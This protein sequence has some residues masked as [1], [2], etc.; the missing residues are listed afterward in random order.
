MVLFKKIIAASPLVT[1]VIAQSGG[2]PK[3]WAA[4]AFINH[5]ERVPMAA[6]LRT[7]L[8]PEGAQQL[9][10]QGTAFRA[11]YIQDG[12][13]DTDYEDI[14]TAYLQ[15]LKA[16][17]IDNDDLDIISQTEEW[18]S[19]GAMA[20]MQGFYPP[21][22]NSFDNSTGGEEIAMNLATSDN[23]T[24]YP[25]NGYQYPNIRTPTYFDPESTEVQGNA[26]CSAWLTETGTNLTENDVLNDLYESTLPF[27]QNLFSTPPLAGTIDID[28]ANIRNAYPLWE[29]V[30]YQYR[31]N[32]TVHEELKNASTT[33]SFLNTYATTMERSSNNYIDSQGDDDPLDVLYSIA[34]RTLAYKVTSQFRSNIRWG[35]SYN[36]L[37]LMFGS[38]EPIVSFIS[39]SGLLT[40]D[41]IIKEPFNALPKP[42]A[43]LV[44]ELFGEDPDFP[45]RQ[46][47]TD[48]LRVRMSYRASADAD[49]PFANQPLFKSG[50]DGIAYSRF[51]QTMNQIGRSPNQ[52]CDVC[53]PTPAPW[54]MLTDSDDHYWGDDSSS[55][56]PVISG[57]IGAIIAIAVLGLVLLALCVLGG[58]RF[59]RKS[60]AETAHDTGAVGGAAGGFKGPEKK[61]GDA[62]VV[63]TKQG[64]HHERVGSWELR[65]PNDLPPQT[66]GIVTKDLGSPHRRSLDDSD[67]DISVMNAAPVKARESV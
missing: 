47:A 32:E 4:V 14:Q 59:R 16:D 12:V 27:Y 62:D 41:N 55:L 18:V 57:V 50:P 22:P 2:G 11:R 21:S 35:S 17:V 46:P 26:R 15:N 56:G 45:D 49:E 30:D 31:H 28:F 48:S 20:F 44:F 53:G 42:G 39:L 29:L 63:V 23:K 7:V 3:V 36:K 64:V 1:G 65:S 34:G 43:A 13:N 58:Y 67:D 38:L 40:R 25:L 61:D 51:M 54:C 60:P 6:N 33:L 8:T 10:R 24:E 19:A 52:W 5:G 9:L 37:T 66:S